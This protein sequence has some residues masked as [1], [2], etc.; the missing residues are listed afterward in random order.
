[1]P[2]GGYAW[3]AEAFLGRH[4]ADGLGGTK[5]AFNQPADV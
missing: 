5:L 1:M 3:L 2:V 4:F